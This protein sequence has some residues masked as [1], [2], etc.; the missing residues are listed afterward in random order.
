MS[1]TNNFK[2]STHAICIGQK[3]KM[4]GPK[5]SKAEFSYQPPQSKYGRHPQHHPVYQIYPHFP[6]PEIFDKVQHLRELKSIQTNMQ[7]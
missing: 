2:D 1:I 5:G 4:R 6:Y 3:Q 7:K